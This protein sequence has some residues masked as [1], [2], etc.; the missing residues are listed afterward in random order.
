MNSF[1]GPLLL[2]LFAVSPVDIGAFT[3]AWRLSNVV[4]FPLVALAAYVLPKLA[5]HI[6]QGDLQALR[7]LAASGGR[8]S[9][10]VG[11]TIFLALLPACGWLLA[12]FDP[13]FESATSA[14]RLLLLAQ[15]VNA[16]P[17]FVGGILLMGK[18]EREAALAMWAGIMANL[19]CGGL[20][21]PLMGIVGAALGLLI[22]SVVWN[23]LM[24]VHVYRRYGISPL[25]FL[26]P[27]RA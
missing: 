20:L 27:A 12:L 8:V 16:A 17:G 2:G 1:V 6:D 26:G 13:A 15:A 5:Q 9:L 4:A 7:R 14:M 25:S 3:V 11:G 10:V 18:H 23:V 22:S 24:A 21:I 19:V